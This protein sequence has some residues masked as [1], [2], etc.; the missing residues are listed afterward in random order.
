MMYVTYTF[1]FEAAHRLFEYDGK[2]SNIHGHNYKVEVAVKGKQGNDGIIVDFNELKYI[3][4]KVRN[5]LDHSLIIFEG[6]NILEGRPKNF[7]HIKII[8]VSWNPTAENFA[9]YIYEYFK[10]ELQKG[11]VYYVRVWETENSSAV[12]VGDRK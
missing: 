1:G 5:V 8:F 10:D 9:R 3:A 6:D 11:K 7:R 12:Y 4:G 2:C